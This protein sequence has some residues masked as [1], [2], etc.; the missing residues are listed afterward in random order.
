VQCCDSA[1]CNEP[2]YQA[3]LSYG[4]VFALIESYA[5]ATTT[6]DLSPLLGKLAEVSSISAIVSTVT[7]YATTTGGSSDVTNLASLLNSLNN[8]GLLNL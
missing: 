3:Y 1:D 8:A 5:S 4:L 6:S 7:E 2:T